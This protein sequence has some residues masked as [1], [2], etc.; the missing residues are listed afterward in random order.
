MTTTTLDAKVND[1]L[2]QK[3]IAG[4]SPTRWHSYQQ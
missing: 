2:A 1:F 3:R 4:R